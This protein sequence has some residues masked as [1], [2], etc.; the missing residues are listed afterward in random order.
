MEG[1]STSVRVVGAGGGGRDVQ[2]DCAAYTEFAARSRLE[3]C[4][5]GPPPLFKCAPASQ[6]RVQPLLVA[7]QLH[8]FNQIVE[9]ML[10]RDRV[11]R[12]AV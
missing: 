2:G 10:H 8:L 4:R 1:Y 12:Q 5:M 6:G 9:H 3:S 7:V 11:A